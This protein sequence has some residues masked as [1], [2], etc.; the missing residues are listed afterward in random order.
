MGDDPDVHLSLPGQ[1]YAGDEA[2]TEIDHSTVDTGHVGVRVKHGT[3]AG[4]HKAKS[5]TF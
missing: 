2:G 3:I 1:P 4:E 5:I